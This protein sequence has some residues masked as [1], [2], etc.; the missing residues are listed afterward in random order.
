MGST[1]SSGLA[2][3]QIITA[4]IYIHIYMYV[5]SFSHFSDPLVRI[6]CELN[7]PKVSQGMPTSKIRH[8]IPVF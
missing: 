4:Y 3:F 2:L 1:S 8:Q 7:F 5:C 6:F